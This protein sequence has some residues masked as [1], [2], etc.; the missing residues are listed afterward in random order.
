MIDYYPHEKD[1]FCI[2][3][4]VYIILQHLPPPF[5]LNIIRIY[6]IYAMSSH[7]QTPKNKGGGFAIGCNIPYNY[8]AKS[9]GGRA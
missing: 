8:C 6:Y 2:K 9:R 1:P 5:K 4:I 7:H 3:F